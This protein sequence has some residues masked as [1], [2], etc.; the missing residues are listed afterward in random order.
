[1]VQAKN[2]GYLGNTQIKRVGIETKYTEAE[3]AEYMKCSK[4]PCHFIEN[5][6]QIISL[7]EGMV[8]FKLRG[9]QDKLIQHYDNNR[10]SVVLASRQSGKS[11]TS[12]AYL[13][14]FLLFHPEVT[15]AVLAN[16]GAIAREMIA[17]IVT[18][19]ESVP[20]FLRQA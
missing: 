6:T 2:E 11:I 20:F 5:Y 3:L 9:Y 12:C 8:P 14:W 17:R 1:M 4:D 7:D 13:L 19:L 10:F 15:V 18:M 16:K